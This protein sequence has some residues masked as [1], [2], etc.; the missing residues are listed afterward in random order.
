MIYGLSAFGQAWTIDDIVIKQTFDDLEPILHQDNDTTYLINFWATWC[1]PCVKELPYIEAL[2]E[3]YSAKA[4]KSILVSLDMPKKVESKLLP[5]LN[6][7]QIISD[8]ILLEDGKAHKWID[9][10]DPSWSGAIPITIVYKGDQREFHEVEF[11]SQ[12]EIEEIVL[13]FLK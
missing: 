12:Q 5:F 3:K 10:V 2:A 13:R 8:V 4:Y 11:H 1:G 9:R 7:N 6:N